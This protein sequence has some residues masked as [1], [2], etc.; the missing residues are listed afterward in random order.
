[1]GNSTLTTRHAW[2]D[3]WSQP[4]LP[5]LLDALKEHHQRHLRKLIDQV[6]EMEK[7]DQA[8]VWYGPSWKWTLHC[9]VRVGKASETLCYIVPNHEAPVVSVPLTE[10]IIASLPRKVS[11]YIREGIRLAK[12]AVKIHWASW[13]PAT[14]IEVEQLLDLIR[15]K[16]A[17]LSGK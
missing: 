11:K 6:G 8:V 15:R 4:T 12:C 7:V 10:T 1:M 17:E 5:N 13:T 14:D 16:H 9:T 2:H 3:R